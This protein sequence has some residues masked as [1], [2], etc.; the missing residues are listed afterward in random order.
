MPLRCP[1][2][3]EI[4][5]VLARAYVVERAW[6]ACRRCTCVRV[7]SELPRVSRLDGHSLLFLRR[8]VFLPPRPSS[9]LPAYS[10]S[11]PA[12]A[13]PPAP[14]LAPLVRR[15]APSP[16]LAPLADVA[17]DVQD[18]LDGIPDKSPEQESNI[19]NYQLEDQ[20]NKLS[21]VEKAK[22]NS[23]QK[24]NSGYSGGVSDVPINFKKGSGVDQR[25]RSVRRF[26]AMVQRTVAEDQLAKD[27]AS[28]LQFAAQLDSQAARDR[29]AFFANRTGNA[30]LEAR[31]EVES[32]A[33]AVT[34]RNASIVEKHNEVFK[35]V[36]Q[37]SQA[38]FALREAL[39]DEQAAV[40]AETSGNADLA[41]TLR[42]SASKKRAK[43]A[44]W[45]NARAMPELVAAD[46][47]AELLAVATHNAQ[48]QLLKAVASVQ[49][50]AAG[51]A[52]SLE[53]V[54]QLQ[55]DAARL[56]TDYLTAAAQSAK[57]SARQPTQYRKRL[58]QALQ[59]AK[60]DDLAAR[61]AGR[62]KTDAASIAK[63]AQAARV[64]HS[65]E[66]E[67]LRLRM[68]AI[69]DRM[70]LQRQVIGEQ[71]RS[72]V[73]AQG[74]WSGSTDPAHRETA[75]AEA[76]LQAQVEH[77]QRAE[78]FWTRLVNKVDFSRLADEQAVSAEA[79]VA[80]GK[81]AHAAALGNLA[82]NTRGAANQARHAVQLAVLNATSQ[83][84]RTM[85]SILEGRS[86]E[87]ARRPDVAAALVAV[88]KA[89]GRRASAAE[90]ASRAIMA[91]DKKKRAAGVQ[92]DEATVLRQSGEAA[93]A[94]A[95]EDMAKL[96]QLEADAMM[97]DAEQELIIGGEDDIGG[98]DQGRAWGD[99]GLGMDGLSKP[100]P[101]QEM[102]TELAAV[103]RLLAHAQKDAA[104][105]VRRAYA[106]ARLHA[107]IVNWLEPMP[108]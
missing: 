45:E 47:R 52:S 35:A 67:A 60:R 95:M 99:G 82:R 107:L 70:A 61:A 90:R 36:K 14:R 20:D 48:K 96:A 40:E 57:L 85:V 59:D 100:T 77:M 30:A 46:A 23:P 3:V 11:P 19:P 80:G 25:F 9:S 6:C 104:A 8:L 79:I 37:A 106:E 49:L 105:T 13:F 55:K 62:G 92:H 89:V 84:K 53:R 94:L 58:E 64:E 66:M 22:A 102:D 10:F 73:A 33:A 78:D 108:L 51:G 21:Q 75:A 56:Q 44:E 91:A 29:A 5:S 39:L 69:A 71:V 38:M 97:E 87:F 12:P 32:Q 68:A 28:R 81:T 54:E 65:V 16:P 4:G 103:S 76:V 34:R 18:V 72:I 63:R 93:K 27:A 2:F 86:K 15:A 83:M 88:A 74:N 101:S 1:R 43:A 26:R 31:A 7:P 50:G 98:A 24:L 42:A 41:A 17:D